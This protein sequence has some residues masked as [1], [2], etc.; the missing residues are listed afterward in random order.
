M[1]NTVRDRP[2]KRFT[3]KFYTLGPTAKATPTT[4][5]LGQL[6]QEFSLYCRGIFAKEKPSKPR[7]IKEGDRSVN[8]QESILVGTWTRSLS[9]I[10]HGMYCFIPTLSKLYAVSGDA[11]DPHGDRKVVHIYIVDNVTLDIRQ[12]MPGAIL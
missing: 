9:N 1:I 12:L 7:E 3:C 5:T 8:E 11:T 6:E 10:T 2:N 4:D